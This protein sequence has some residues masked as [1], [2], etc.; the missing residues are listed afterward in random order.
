[1]QLLK[2]MLKMSNTEEKFLKMV[3]QT[4]SPIL[5]MS[6]VPHPKHEIF[7]QVLLMRCMTG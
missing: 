6:I 2:L 4:D 5:Y 7:Q 3:M 1:M